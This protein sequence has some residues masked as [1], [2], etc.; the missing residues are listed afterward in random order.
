MTRLVSCYS[1]WSTCGLLPNQ[2]W[3][4]QSG[5]QAHGCGKSRSSP[6]KQLARARPDGPSFISPAIVLG[7]GT[8]EVLPEQNLS[9][10]EITVFDSV[11]YSKMLYAGVS[12]IVFGERTKVSVLLHAPEIV[13]LLYC[14]EEEPVLRPRTQSL[15]KIRVD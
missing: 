5:S 7:I 8:H 14:L 10:S 2:W 15:V 6:T 13:L 4:P 12:Q 9:F 11:E 3:E 1:N